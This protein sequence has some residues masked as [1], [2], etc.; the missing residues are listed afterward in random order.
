MF[1]KI[2]PVI[3]LFLKEKSLLSLYVQDFDIVTSVMPNLCKISRAIF[4]IS[5]LYLSFLLVLKW[6]AC[7]ENDYKTL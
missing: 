5:I 4:L 7:S 2:L 3:L 1:R 6:P